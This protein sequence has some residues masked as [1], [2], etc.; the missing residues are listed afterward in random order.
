MSHISKINGSNGGNHGVLFVCSAF[1]AP[2]S[3]CEPHVNGG[4]SREHVLERACGAYSQSH[5]KFEK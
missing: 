3:H 4:A 1:G 5:Q 2:K